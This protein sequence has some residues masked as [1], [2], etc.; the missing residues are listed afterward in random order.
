MSDI[1]NALFIGK[2]MVKNKQRQ[3]SIFEKALKSGIFLFLRLNQWSWRNLPQS[4]TDLHTIR[5]YGRLLHALVRVRANRRQ[6][7]G[8][9]FLRNR[10]E[11]E[12]LGRIADQKDK[13]SALRIAVLA[14][15]NGAEVYSVLWKIR[16]RRPDLK[17]T[18]HAVDISEEV[19]ELAQKGVYSLETPELVEAPIFERMTET[20]MQEIFDRENDRVMIKSWIKEGIIWHLGDARDQGI[21]NAI[22]PQEIVVA[23]NFLCHMD[24][25]DAEECLRNIARLVDPGGYLFVS[26]I[27]LDVRTKV[28]R[29]LCWEPVRDLQAE[30]HDGDS[31][32]R[33]DWPFKWWGLEPF[34]RSRHDWEIRYASV[35]HLG[36]KN[37]RDYTVQ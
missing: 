16:S 9:Y 25:P 1:S 35:F 17:V 6:Y 11:L 5:S 3:Q 27:D 23:N 22:G 24:P 34:D 32:L 14:C 10:P 20:E 18:L 13:G 30:I 37:D 19:L 36:E 33:R 31:V 21:L 7:F 4:F 8:T 29:D 2:E 15:S 26:G 12:L 28:A